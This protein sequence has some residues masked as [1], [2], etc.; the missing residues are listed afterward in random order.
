LLVF[1][2]CTTPRVP[3]ATLT[4]ESGATAYEA[5]SLQS[6]DLQQ[7]LRENLGH[8]PEAWD[9][10]TLCWVGFYYQPALELARA[11]WQTERA[12]QH[13]AA[14]RPNP[15][16]TLAPGYDFTR[17]PGL[18]PWMPT[19]SADWLLQTAGKRAHQQDVARANAEA[20]RLAIVTAAWQ[21]RS[22][23]RKALNEAEISARRAVLLREQADLQ[24]KFVALL[25]QRFQ[26]GSVAATDV[27][28]ARTALLRAESAAADA[29]TQSAVSRARVATALGLPVAALQGVR[30]PRPPAAAPLAGTDL[31]TARRTAL[32][33]RADLLSALAR[34]QAAQAA[35][36]LELA[37][38]I[39]DVHFGPGYQWDQGQNKWT[40]GLTI[41]LP[42]FNRNAGPIA[43]AVARRAEA[44]AQFNVVQN[45]AVG[46]IDAAVA[47]VES[48]ERQL[49]RAR[50]LREQVRQQA[51]LAQQQLQLGAADQ[52]EAQSARLDATT[53]DTAV[54]DAENAAAS[55]AGQLE[56]ALQVPFSNLAALTHP[57]SADPAP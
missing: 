21:M 22:E 6:R 44:A 5:R 57:A 11:Q 20:A 1:A 14:A 4:A 56:D 18:S 37:R 25:Q 19:V 27:S 10:E 40:L 28:I 49:Q 17:E 47:A 38:R 26:L 31:P 36:E 35:L 29:E 16:L 33:S 3:P 12:A 43:E 15:S 32:R 2:G 9:F 42:V 30:L 45:Q 41:E 46:A 8:E 23:L 13:T 24:G 48:A 50:E 51:A 7:F 52:L 34:Y 39:P 55:A 54:L 53:A